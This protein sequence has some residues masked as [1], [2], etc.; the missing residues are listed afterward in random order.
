MIEE[1]GVGGGT[2]AG[3]REEETSRV[4]LAYLTQSHARASEPVNEVLASKRPRELQQEK[5]QLHVT[6]VQTVVQLGLHPF[7]STHRLPFRNRSVNAHRTQTR[8]PVRNAHRHPP[9]QP[10]GKTQTV[11]LSNTVPTIPPS[12]RRT[13]SSSARENPC[14]RPD[15]DVIKSAA[16]MWIENRDGRERGE[17][18]GAGEAERRGLCVTHGGER[19]DGVGGYLTCH[20]WWAR[21][22][23]GG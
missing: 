14:L 21:P 7:P 8:W 3:G 18:G 17:V 9:S 13:T 6:A 20:A 22:A 15:H 23:S 12:I 10:R 2:N 1:F 19:N 5:Y 11:R 16:E 4:W